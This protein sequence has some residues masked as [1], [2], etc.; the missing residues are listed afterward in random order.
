MNLPWIIASANSSIA[1]AFNFCLPR[2]ASRDTARNSPKISSFW[3]WFIFL[4]FWQCPIADTVSPP[5]RCWSFLCCRYIA[6]DTH[7]AAVFFIYY[8]IDLGSFWCVTF[9]QLPVLSS[10]CL[11]TIIVEMN[12]NI[13]PFNVSSKWIFTL[14]CSSLIDT[15]SIQ[16]W[17]LM[18]LY[19]K[20]CIVFSLW[21]HF[22][23][24]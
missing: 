24:Y 6:C 17:W 14:C 8:S 12:N 11:T 1:F 3:I 16:W 23:R 18:Y 22:R 13:L 21:L 20:G 7:T 19:R 9:G 5:S 2:Q 10:L 4:S 15:Q